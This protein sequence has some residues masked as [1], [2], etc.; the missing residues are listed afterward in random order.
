MRYDQS[1]RACKRLL[2]SGAL[3]DPVLATIEMRAIPHWMPWQQRQGWVTLRI[4]SIHHLDTFRF[5]FGDPARVLASTRPD[6]RRAAI[7]APG[8][9]LPVHPGIR[10]WVADRR[11]GRRLGWPR[12]RRL[13]GGH[14][15]SLA[16]GRDRG[17]GPRDDRLAKLSRSYAQHARRYDHEFRRMGTAAMGSS[18]VSRCLCRADGTAI[19]CPRRGIRTRDR[20]SGQFATMALVDACYLSAS[21]HRAVVA[22]GNYG[23]LMGK[24]AGLTLPRPIAAFSFRQ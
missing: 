10:R 14:V 11:M 12:P 16:R 20:R 7:F 22:R 13:G 8:W 17:N 9:D 3:G 2:E 15:Y 5:W 18:L 1:V 24:I 23:R 19:V 6:P 21:E 4:M